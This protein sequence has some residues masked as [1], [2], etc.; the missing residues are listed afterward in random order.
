MVR[1]QL[2]HNRNPKR[3]LRQLRTS[4][5]RLMIRTRPRDRRPNHMRFPPEQGR[6]LEGA[7]GY[8]PA[9]SNSK[10]FR[11]TQVPEMSEA[12]GGL[13]HNADVM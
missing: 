10:N 8:I 3:R 6:P 1:N 13:V 2:L 12:N 4:I 9:Q 5:R 11:P 7:D